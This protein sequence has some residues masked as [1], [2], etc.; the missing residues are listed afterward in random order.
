MRME[1]L[2]FI[3]DTYIELPESWDEVSF[4]QFIKLQECDN[5]DL[6]AVSILTGVSKEDW[7]QSNDTSLYYYCM[8][9][10]STWIKSGLDDINEIETRKIRWMSKELEFGDIGENTVA[11]F[12][13][14]KILLGKYEEL[15]KTKPFDAMEMYYPLICSI[16]LQPKASKEKYDYSKAKELVS[17]IKELP[18]PMVIG[19]VNFFLMRYIVSVSGIKPNVQK[20]S[21]LW[22]RLKQ[23]LVTY[24]KR[25]AL[26]L[27]LTAWQKE[28]LRKKIILSS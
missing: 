3:G 1:R 4:S 22:K 21:S 19:V 20:G 17:Q 26:R 9:K 10:I 23:G 14:V 6:N 2:A 28:I 13:D 24:I 12:E 15:Y 18:A 8:N 7:A 11:Q 16:Y 25:L 5:V 27:Y